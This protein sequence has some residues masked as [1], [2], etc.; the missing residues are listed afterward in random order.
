MIY[1]TGSALLMQQYNNNYTT[2]HYIIYK[3][4]SNWTLAEMVMAA[5]FLFPLF[6]LRAIDEN[7]DREVFQQFYSLHFT[8]GLFLFQ[9]GEKI[10]TGPFEKKLCV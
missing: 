1:S 2:Q 3:T 10:H 7:S 4:F 6:A 5:G 9:V 8:V